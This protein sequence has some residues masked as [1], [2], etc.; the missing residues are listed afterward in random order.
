MNSL[1]LNKTKTYISLSILLIINLLFSIKYLKRVTP[2]YIIISIAIICLYFI[3][4]K[5]QDYFHFLKKRIKTFNFVCFII[6]FILSYFLF[7]KI[8]VESLNTDRWSVI[9]SFWNNYFNGEYVYFAVSHANN[10]PGPMPFYYILALP[11]YF[12]GELGYFSLLGVFAFYLLTYLLRKPIQIR[13]TYLIL[14]M[15]SPFYLWE[16]VTRSNIFLNSTLILMSLIY[17]FKTVKKGN[18]ILNGVIIGLLLSTRNV[19][20]IPYIIAFLYA[21]KSKITN[22]KNTFIIGITA[23]ITFT[24]TFL[25]FVINHCDDFMIMNPF[26]IQSSYLMPIEFSFTCI[27]L[28]FLS[29]FITKSIND[30]YLYSGLFLFLTITLHFYW[31]IVQ[32]NIYDALFDSKADISYF[33]LCIP[34]IIFHLIEQNKEIITPHK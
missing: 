26:I 8:P 30:V 1:N 12:I 21:L 28:S 4:W 34:F 29:F 27:I 5:Y 6:L 18:L 13:T 9:T 14:I 31:K 16:I 20:V 25:P 11:F 24:A 2:N 33:I 22:F 15:I 3:I 10:Y 7:Q 32:F 17:F 19:F 23:L